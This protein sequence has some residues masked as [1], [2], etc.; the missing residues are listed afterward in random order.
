MGFL[1]SFILPPVFLYFVHQPEQLFFAS[2]IFT[3]LS[4][5][6]LW[7]TSSG[8]FWFHYVFSDFCEQVR[9]FWFILVVVTFQ[10]KTVPRAQE[11]LLQLCLGFVYD[12]LHDLTVV[13]PPLNFVVPSCLWIFPQHS[14]SPLHFQFFWAHRLFFFALRVSETRFTTFFISPTFHWKMYPTSA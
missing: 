13:G 2:T 9:S 4:G 3:A 10:T 6:W 11:G 14:T 8:F 1:S 12:T 5:F 7:F